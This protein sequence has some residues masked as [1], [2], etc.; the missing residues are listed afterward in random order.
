MIKIPPVGTKVTIALPNIFGH[1]VVHKA[2]IMREPYRHGYRTKCGAWSLYDVAQGDIPCYMVELRPYRKR[3][4]YVVAVDE[5]IDL[6]I[7]W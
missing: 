4:I 1:P 7:G 5:I 2:T 3:N 6:R